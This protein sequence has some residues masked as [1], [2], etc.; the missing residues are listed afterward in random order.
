MCPC[1]LGPLIVIARNCGGTYIL[2]E[3]N[4]SLLDQP[5]AAFHVILY[6]A[7]TSIPLPPLEQLLDTLE[8]RLQEL[9]DLNVTNFNDIKSDPVRGMDAQKPIW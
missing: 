1:Y 7:W 6:F 5:I 2:A 8:T 9:T 3:L 4:G